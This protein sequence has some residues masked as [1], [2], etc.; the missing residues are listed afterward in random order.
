M[1]VNLE[2]AQKRLKKSEVYDKIKEIENYMSEGL[3]ERD[4]CLKAGKGETYYSVFK[5]RQGELE[6]SK[7]R[8]KLHQ[9]KLINE[10][11]AKEEEKIKE[12]QNQIN[13]TRSYLSGLKI[14][15]KYL[16]E[17]DE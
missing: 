15:S 11:I 5:F 16:F 10:A 9:E 2:K 14:A 7:T 8:E 13:E 3:H 6:K 4:A 1:D 12:L 17:K